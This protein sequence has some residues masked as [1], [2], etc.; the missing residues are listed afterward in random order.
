MTSVTT[1]LEYKAQFY[2]AFL[3]LWATYN[4]KNLWKIWE[5]L[6]HPTFSRTKYQ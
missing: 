6:W 2:N 1:A 3:R 4:Q 5:M